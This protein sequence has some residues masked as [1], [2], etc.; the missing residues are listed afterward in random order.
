M[1]RFARFLAAAFLAAAPLLAQAP[2]AP[3]SELADQLAARLGR[4]LGVKTVVGEPLKVGSVTLIPILTLDVTFGGGAVASTPD[5]KKPTPSPAGF[6]MSGEA[7]PV[8]FVAI[9]GKGTRFLAVPGRS[10]K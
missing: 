2:P 5:P 3:A 1:D 9:T 4:E 7:R 10:Q 8:G 6:Y